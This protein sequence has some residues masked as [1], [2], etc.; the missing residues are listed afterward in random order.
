M[1]TLLQISEVSYSL[2]KH[3]TSS[4]SRGVYSAKEKW[5]W[6]D[7]YPPATPTPAVVL[8]DCRSLHEATPGQATQS[9]WT[10]NTGYSLCGTFMTHLNMK[11]KMQSHFS[12][13]TLK[14]SNHI[15]PLKMLED[16]FHKQKSVCPKQISTSYFLAK[17]LGYTVGRL[18]W[19]TF[20]IYSHYHFP[21]C[22]SIFCCQKWS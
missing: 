2:L 19:R 9:M 7:K 5:N 1:V 3:F 6:K 12:A 16:L 10:E 8:A 21:P 17:L 20:P 11:T 14:R 22:V 4:C 13:M 15:S 18:R